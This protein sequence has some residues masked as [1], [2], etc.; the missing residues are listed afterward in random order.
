MK[1][2]QDAVDVAIIVRQF[3]HTEAQTYHQSQGKIKQDDR[4]D[5]KEFRQVI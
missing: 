1:N 5:N 4:P 3:L 2:L